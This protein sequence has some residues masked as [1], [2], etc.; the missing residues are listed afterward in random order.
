VRPWSA[1]ESGNEE[2]EA[3]RL[4]AASGTKR[5][6]EA[7][8]G[9]RVVERAGSEGTNGERKGES[10]IQTEAAREGAEVW[11]AKRRRDTSRR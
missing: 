10:E 7:V 6:D 8:S 5:R 2:E 11:V 9:C 1:A 3:K 4:R